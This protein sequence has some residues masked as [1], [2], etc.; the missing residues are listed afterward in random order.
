M[1]RFRSPV[2]F[3]K[4]ICAHSAILNHLNLDYRL[5]RRYAFEENRAV[6]LAG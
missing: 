5:I 1:Q 3:Q 6:A 2:R 4:F